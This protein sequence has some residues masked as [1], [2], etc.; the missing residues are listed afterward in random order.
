MTTVWSSDDPY[1][2]DDD[3][4]DEDDYECLDVD[5]CGK[6]CTGECYATPYPF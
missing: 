4:F 5:V 2:Y 6:V 3:V 1:H